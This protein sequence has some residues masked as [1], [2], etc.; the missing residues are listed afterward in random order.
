MLVRRI[1]GAHGAHTIFAA[2]ELETVEGDIVGVL[3]VEAGLPRLAAARDFNAD[4]AVVVALRIEH[5]WIVVAA[6]VL[7]GEREAARVATAEKIDFRTR[8]RGRQRVSGCHRR[9]ARCP[10]TLA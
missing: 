1:A 10:V 7:L 2:N 3:E 5:D 4:R 6:A 9:L 8:P